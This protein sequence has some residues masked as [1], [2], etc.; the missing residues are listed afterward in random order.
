MDVISERERERERERRESQKEKRDTEGGSLM[1]N[2]TSDD[3]DGDKNNNNN[4][5]T[6]EKI[7]PTLVLTT[8]ELVI[9]FIATSTCRSYRIHEYRLR[10]TKEKT[11]QHRHVRD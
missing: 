2:R 3:D 4:G 8:F 10:S 6:N 1:R 7:R 5:L 11:L 9:L